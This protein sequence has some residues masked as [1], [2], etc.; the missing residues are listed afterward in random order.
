MKK[1]N[2][3]AIAAIL[4]LILGIIMIILGRRANILPPTITGVGFIVIAIAFW[5]LRN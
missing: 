2:L 4:L 3:L 1:N 5:G